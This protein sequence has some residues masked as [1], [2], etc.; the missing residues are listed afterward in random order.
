MVH[1]T[2]CITRLR[3]FTTHSKRD[4]VRRHFRPKRIINTNVPQETRFGKLLALNVA[5]KRMFPRSRWLRFSLSHS[6]MQSRICARFLKH[7]AY[8]IDIKHDQLI[9]HRD[10]TALSI[11]CHSAKVRNK[12]RGLRKSSTPTHLRSLSV[13]RFSNL[14]ALMT[15]RHIFVPQKASRWTVFGWGK[16]IRIGFSLP[17]FATEGARV[18]H[19]KITTRPILFPLPFKTNN[20]HLIAPQHLFPPPFSPKHDGLVDRRRQQQ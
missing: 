2:V 18:T 11:W 20:G 4:A 10:S 3:I 5:D 12:T 9:N 6:I 19:N 1:A 13:S 14:D 7:V 15:C 16:W 17:P 8:F